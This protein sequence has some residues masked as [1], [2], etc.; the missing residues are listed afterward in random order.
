MSNELHCDL[1]G[2]HDLVCRHNS[3]SGTSLFQR[4]QAA[5][6]YGP[7]VLSKIDD[8]PYSNTICMLVQSNLTST[9]TLCS[10]T[11][12]TLISQS[13]ISIINISSPLPHPLGFL[14]LDKRNRTQ[15]PGSSSLRLLSASHSALFQLMLRA[16]HPS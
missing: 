6:Y 8:C 11:S 14:I 10:T 3:P 2:Y 1:V 7:I 9:R 5:W 15:A 12:Y 13:D 4:C 16:S